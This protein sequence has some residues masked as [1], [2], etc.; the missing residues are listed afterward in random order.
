MNHCYNLSPREFI[1]AKTGEQDQD[2][3]VIQGWDPKSP[4]ATTFKE[5]FYLTN[6]IQGNAI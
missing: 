2:K 4:A 6:F 3:A 5:M 1:K